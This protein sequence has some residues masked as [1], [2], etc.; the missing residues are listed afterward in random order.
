MKKIIAFILSVIMMFSMT[1]V[2]YAADTASGPEAT[3]TTIDNYM[4][5]LEE[6]LEGENFFVKLIARLVI[7]GV[8]LGFIKIEDFD[9][10][11]DNTA[12]DTDNDV[13]G[14]KP[15]Q[16]DSANADW[17]DG[18]ELKL[19]PSQSLP[20]TENGVTITDIKITKEH[21]D[22]LRENY[23]GRPVVQKYR[24]KITVKGIVE[25]YTE[26]VTDGNISSSYYELGIQ[27]YSSI[28]SAKEDNRCYTLK[29]ETDPNIDSKL[30]YN[31]DGSFEYECYQYHI[32]EDFD[33][34]YIAYLYV[35]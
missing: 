9:A 19:H 23:Y 20:Y 27:F 33:S 15:T 18:T 25:N 21:C 3:T 6:K 28:N 30:V 14:D 5:Y 35:F 10:W 4:D 17:E 26:Q 24:Y 16:D 2:S 22:E 13:E 11:F 29:N 1:S 8:M 32:F 34:F 7:V 12:P 31:D